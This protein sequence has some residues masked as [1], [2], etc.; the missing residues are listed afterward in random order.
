ML[1]GATADV[2][3]WVDGGDPAETAGNG[4]QWTVQ[5]TEAMTA[6]LGSARK[7]ANF[8][9]NVEA[10]LRVVRGLG[11]PGLVL[12]ENVAG[13]IADSD[14]FLD[15]NSQHIV[16]LQRGAVPTDPRFNEQWG[17]SND[18][19]YDVDAPEAWSIT[20]GSPDVIVAVI[21]NGIDITHPEIQH[22]LWLPNGE[23]VVKQDGFHGTAIIGAISG[24]QNND[25]GGSGIAPGVTILP[26][27]RH[28]PGVTV[29]S[30]LE[31]IYRL[32]K[33]GHEI[34][35]VNLSQN[36][37]GASD[38]EFA[39]IVEAI[40]RLG[41]DFG[42]HGTLV[43]KT[44]GNAGTDF[45]DGPNRQLGS[46]G[47]SNLITVTSSAQD[48]TLP[49]VRSSYGRSV[50]DLTA[51]F[52]SVLP[53]PP[54]VESTDGFRYGGGASVAT[55]IVSREDSSKVIEACP[56]SQWRTLFVL[57]RYGGQRCPSETLNLRWQ[58]I[59]WHNQRMVQRQSITPVESL[60]RFRSFPSCYPILKK[61]LSW[62]RMGRSS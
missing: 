42:E 45:D 10:P 56:D 48:G 32:R 47:L 28:Q 1:S 38:E 20:T 19:D 58:D 43:V 9:R 35:I 23:W 31:E 6:Q 39:A 50:V 59:D 40:R 7:L 62:L 14:E 54:G 61:L 11:Q 57:A 21:D 33:E 46:F 13:D 15:R 5:L 18:D 17:L 44:A 2:D 25:L 3:P 27:D 34:R 41:E 29:L 37:T 24:A 4:F 60:D 16:S 51:P 52:A 22:S 8:L 30:S 55:A 49:A 12:L 53:V 36:L 26:F